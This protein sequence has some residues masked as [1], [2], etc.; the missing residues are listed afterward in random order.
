MG[1][2]PFLV[3][4]SVILILAQRLSRKICEQCKEEERIPETA[5]IDIGFSDEEINT[6][7]CFNGKGCQTCSGTGYKGR[8]ALYE[9]MPVN[10]EI[11]DMIL[12]GASASDLKKATI[13]LGMKTLRMSGLTKIK[14]G[15][16][17]VKEV[18][19]VTFGD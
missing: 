12:K 18:L 19:R 2:E 10:E 13:R 9:V 8:I 11:K 6:F 17:S 5:L 4:A 16:T 14:E 7:K 1:V 15:V 3:S